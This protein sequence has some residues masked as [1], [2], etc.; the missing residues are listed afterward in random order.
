MCAYSD[1]EDVVFDD[2][3]DG[4]WQKKKFWKFL[5]GGR[6]HSFQAEYYFLWALLPSNSEFEAWLKLTLFVPSNLQT[7]TLH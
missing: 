7:S 6:E 5:V 3:N 2:D 1:N 4:D